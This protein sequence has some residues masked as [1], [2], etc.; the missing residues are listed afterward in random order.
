ME[1]EDG[2]VRKKTERDQDDEV[3]GEEED[4]ETEDTSILEPEPGEEEGG[5]EVDTQKEDQL[6]MEDEVGQD[7]HGGMDSEEYLRNYVN[8]DLRNNPEHEYQNISQS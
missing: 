3:M 7:L 2:S 6:L 4:E 5:E 8:S 1:E